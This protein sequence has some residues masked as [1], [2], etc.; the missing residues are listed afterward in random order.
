MRLFN[1]SDRFAVSALPGSPG[2]AQSITSTGSCDPLSGEAA[3]FPEG[4]SSD[5]TRGGGSPL[6]ARGAGATQRGAAQPPLDLSLGHISTTAHRA[7]EFEGQIDVVSYGPFVVSLDYG[8]MFVCVTVEDLVM[9]S[10]AERRE[11]A[12]KVGKLVKVAA[13]S[14]MDVEGWPL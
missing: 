10:R 1:S 11:S 9:F 12:R 14:G 3:R 5:A 6:P 13:N 7:A 8:H 2:Q 4:E